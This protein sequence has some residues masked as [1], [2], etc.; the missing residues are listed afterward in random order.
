MRSTR[1][2]LNCVRSLNLDSLFTP[3]LYLSA[4]IL[5]EPKRTVYVCVH[6]H[7]RVCAHV[8]TRVHACV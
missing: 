1:A 4:G 7:P 8:Y 5:L 3:D 6:V 2:V